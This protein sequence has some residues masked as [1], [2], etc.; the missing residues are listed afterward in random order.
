MNGNKAEV[1][2]ARLKKAEIFN[3]VVLAVIVTVVFYF[4]LR[5][6]NTSNLVPSTASVT[7]SF[8]ADVHDI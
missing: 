7:T 1:E 8:L 5:A 6:F 2:I 4:I 3:M